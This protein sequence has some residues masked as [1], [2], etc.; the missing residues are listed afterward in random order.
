N[1]KSGGAVMLLFALVAILWVG[2]LATVLTRLAIS[3]RRE[4]M[5]DAGAVRLTKNP[6]AMMRALQRIAGMADIPNSPGDIKMMCFENAQ[7]FLGLFATHP[8]IEHRIAVLS[9]T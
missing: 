9:Q 6:G 7:P 5:A 1:N 8:P 2:Y 4:F 3:R